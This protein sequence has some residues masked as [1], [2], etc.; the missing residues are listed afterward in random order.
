MLKVAFFNSK[1][2]A[3]KSTLAVHVGVVAAFDQRV[4]LLDADPQGTLRAWR[5]MRQVDAPTVMATKASTLA[6]DLADLEKRGV[7]LA[8][9]DCP[10]YIT[11]ESAK[12]VSLVDFVVV[13]VQPTMPDISGCQFAISIIKAARKPFVFIINRAPARA[14][15]VA[16]AINALKGHA[17]V[18]PITVGNRRAF[19]R[20]LMSGQSVTEFNARSAASAEASSACLWVL[21][22]VGKH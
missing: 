14:P 6:H 7:Q 10:P 22:K 5:E 3:G 17:E 15:E 16:L 13:P 20:A 18:C 9:V 8:I 2:G 11:A 1:G 21:K 19:S 4:A 12:L